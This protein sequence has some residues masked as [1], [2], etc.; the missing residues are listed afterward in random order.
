M[1]IEGSV[2]EVI[3]MSG[4]WMDGREISTVS[5]NIEEI[6]KQLGHQIP[7]GLYCEVSREW[8]SGKEISTAVRN[9]EEVEKQLGDRGSYRKQEY[10][11]LERVDAGPLFYLAIIGGVF[12]IIF[13]DYLREC[14]FS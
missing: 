13:L 10:N 4:K 7:P 14:F 1:E 11:M 5:R 3:I 6:E 2:L 12:L 8:M 9:I